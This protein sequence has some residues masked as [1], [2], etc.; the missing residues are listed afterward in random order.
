[1]PSCPDSTKRLSVP[2]I[3]RKYPAS[4]GYQP[5]ETFCARAAVATGS[6]FSAETTST[7]SSACSW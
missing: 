1:M 6:A 4:L 3:S 5:G 7:Q 2:A